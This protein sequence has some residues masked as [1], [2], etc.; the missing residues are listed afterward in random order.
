MKDL[1][2]LRTKTFATDLAFQEAIQSVLQSPMDAHTRYS[3]P[4][5]YDVTFAQPVAFH[6][7]IDDSQEP[8]L[9]F[10]PNI[11]TNN[12][13]QVVPNGVDPYSV[14]D[15]EIVLIDGLEWQSAL[16]S[17]ADRNV[18]RSNDQS[19][20]FNVAVRDFAW[21][22]QRSYVMPTSSSVSY[23]YLNADGTLSHVQF[24]WTASYG[25]KLANVSACVKP[26]QQSHKSVR[27][28]EAPE[29][30][31]RISDKA[32]VLPSV[33]ANDDDR[34][35]ILPPGRDSSI[36]CFVSK[37]SDSDRPTLVMKIG[38]FSPPGDSYLVAWNGFLDDVK[39][40]LSVKYHY[41]VVDV[42]QN[43]GGYV[44]LGLRTLTMLIKE[45]NENH[46]LVQMNYDIGHSPIMTDYVAKVNHNQPFWN[47]KDVEQIMDPATKQPF[48]DGKSYYDVNR[49]VTQG[50][51][52][53]QRTKLFWLDCHEAMDIHKDF[54]PTRFAPPEDLV[55]LT[56]GTCGST[57][58]SFSKIAQEAK[59]ATLVSL[60]GLWNLPMDVASFA[61]GFVCNPGLLDQIA[62][63][64]G[65]KFPQFETSVRWQFDWAVWYSKLQPS[66]AIQFTFQ[67]AD[68]R[69]PFWDFP[70]PSIA[71]DSS[72]K[73]VSDLYD[74]LI[75]RFPKPA[76]AH[77]KHVP[78][79]WIV[80]VSLLSLF[81]L[82][83]WAVV[84]FRS[85]RRGD[86]LKRGLL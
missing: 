46:D 81:L 63:K 50:G 7:S 58:A 45:F 23:S 76:H 19:I 18:D 48:P 35:V 70:H 12:Y 73:A 83:T 22:S 66:R 21:R 67:N 42:V 28:E 80:A 65:Q 57:C 38:S 25:P 47:P 1:N 20:R 27:D 40:C 17:W 3:K 10:V 34:T 53:A 79:G 4:L 61:G 60:G 56:D 9:K 36:S 55:F 72:A 68:V 33:S 82:L 59:K 39:T 62:N 75:D 11:I 86:V 64:F 78:V 2:D 41:V 26:P 69:I 8:R 77:S 84:L 13:K 30:H 85:R 44:C 32:M 14:M 29:V 6:V 31:T 54:V 5:C 24:E 43:G 74:S 52:T 51:V 16:V 15:R 37:R 49:N 71:V